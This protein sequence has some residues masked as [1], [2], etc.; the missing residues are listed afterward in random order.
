VA[1]QKAGLLEMRRQRDE[2]AVL[3]RE[4]DAAQKAYDQIAQKL[5]QSS[6]EGQV[7]QSNVAVLTAAEQSLRPSSPLILLNTL[8]AV[9]IGG[10]L[11]IAAAFVQEMR[12]RR[13]RSP[14]D[15]EYILDLPVLAEVRRPSRYLTVRRPALGVS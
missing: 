14:A 10:L 6:L 1:E 7:T 2:L 11:G 3:M 9:F 8:I 13:V 5:T 15:L 4:G 12:D